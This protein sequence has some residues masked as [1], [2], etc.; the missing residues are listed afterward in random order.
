MSN[1]KQLG[2][3]VE[4]LG[5][6]AVADPELPGDHAGPHTRCSHL[7]DLEANMVGERPA[8]YKDAAQ[9]VHPALALR[10]T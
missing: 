2:L 9:L 3:P 5:D 6:A 4:Y 8:I 7:D 10:Q 1:F